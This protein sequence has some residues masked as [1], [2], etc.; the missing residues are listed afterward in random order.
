MS[1]V[2]VISDTHFG[3]ESIAKHRGFSSAEEQD[4]LIV[5][6]WNRVVNKRDTVWVLGDITMEKANYEILRRLNGTINVVLG[7]H[8]LPHHTKVLSGFVNKIGGAVKYKGCL[9]T[10][11]PIHESEVNR[12]R[13]VIHGHVHEKTI[14]F[15]EKPHDQYVNVCCEVINYT[16]ILFENLL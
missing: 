16:P 9:L 2:Y 14:M 4:N 7:N 12:F 11:V 8:D 5:N 3:H 1:K 15:G 13:K 6:N 10:H